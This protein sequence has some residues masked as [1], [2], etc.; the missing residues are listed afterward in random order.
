[1]ERRQLLKTSL[2]FLG[3]TT[4]ISFVY[5][6]SKFLVPPKSSAQDAQVILD[7]D[8]IPTGTAKEVIYNDVPLVIINR[9]GSG[10]IAL[11]RV[12]THLG[13]LVGYDSFNNKLVCPCHAGEFDLEG[14]VLSGPATK[15]LKRYPLKISS[16][17]ITIG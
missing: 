14:N 4:L 17:Q 3:T 2:A 8:Q 11:S 6:A 7:K 9:R 13:C 10:F 15:S 1:M 16:K 5:P 12:C